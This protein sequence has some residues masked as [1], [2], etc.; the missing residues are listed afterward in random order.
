MK[1]DV[2]SCTRPACWPPYADWPEELVNPGGCREIAVY[3]PNDT[4][5]K[6]IKPIQE[7]RRIGEGYAAPPVCFIKGVKPATLPGTLTIE[8]FAQPAEPMYVI[9]NLIART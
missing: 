2:R 8:G 6:P 9:H 1:P 3:C 5:Q 4:A 7:R